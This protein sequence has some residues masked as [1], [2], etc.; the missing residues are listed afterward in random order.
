MPVHIAHEVRCPEAREAEAAGHAVAAFVQCVL[1]SQ[2]QEGLQGC[3]VLGC[4]WRQGLAAGDGWVQ[5]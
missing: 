1:P 3:K 4:V 2:C 5:V